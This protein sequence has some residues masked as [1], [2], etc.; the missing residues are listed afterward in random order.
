MEESV[1]NMGDILEV[2]QQPDAN[3]DNEMDV[4]VGMKR[5]GRPKV[6]PVWQFFVFNDK[7]STCSIGKCNYK[8]EQMNLDTIFPLCQSPTKNRTQTPVSYRN[9]SNKR[10]MRLVF[11]IPHSRAFIRDERCVKDYDV[12]FFWK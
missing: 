9:N 12:T 1:E 8:G 3:N 5:S 11:R 6:D 2:E 4:A 10:T 7:V